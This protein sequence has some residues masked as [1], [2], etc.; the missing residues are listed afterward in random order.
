MADDRWQSSN[1]HHHMTAQQIV[2]GGR[3]PFLRDM[4]EL[5]GGHARKQFATQMRAST[6]AARA[7]I[8]LAGLSLR[9][10]Y[11]LLNRSRRHGRMRDQSEWRRA[12]EAYRGKIRAGI[13]AEVGVDRGCD[14]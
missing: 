13:I 4:G 2:D 14:S 5:D 10:C 7:V 11:Q 8:Q 9:E 12:D 6:G 1:D 3:N